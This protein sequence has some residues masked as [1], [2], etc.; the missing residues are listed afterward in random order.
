M[1]APQK[2]ATAI[3]VIMIEALARSSVTGG[4]CSRADRTTAPVTGRLLVKEHADWQ[5]QLKTDIAML[6]DDRACNT[7]IVEVFCFPNPTLT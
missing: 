3:L 2:T 1:S 5:K 7:N 6:L 4:R